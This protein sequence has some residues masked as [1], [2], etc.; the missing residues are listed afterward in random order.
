MKKAYLLI[1]FGIIVILFFSCTYMP[2]DD[3]KP[4]EKEIPEEVSFKTDVLP[5]FNRCTGCHP[6][7]AGLD[8]SSGNAF[9]SIMDGRV[10]KANPVKSKIYTVPLIDHK[11]KEY[12]D[13]EA[14]II[15]K[16]IEAGALNN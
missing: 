13:N 1:T 12:S 4:E 7:K 11:D 6:S 10:D 14:A 9:E 15:L 3:V 5:I 8:L 2:L 16:W